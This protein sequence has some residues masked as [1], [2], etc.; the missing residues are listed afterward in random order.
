MT[1]GRAFLD[2]FPDPVLQ[3]S[4]GDADSLELAPKS[5]TVYVEEVQQIF[6]VFVTPENP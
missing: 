6:A 4:E 1:S 3:P 2:A 5:V